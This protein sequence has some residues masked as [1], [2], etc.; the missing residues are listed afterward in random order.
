MLNFVYYLSL[1]LTQLKN[2]TLLLHLS[3]WI[4]VFLFIGLLFYTQNN[5][6]PKPIMVKVCFG[7]VLFYINYSILIPRFLFKR[8]FALYILLAA[9]L[10]AVVTV[11]YTHIKFSVLMFEGDSKSSK[12]FFTAYLF[13]IPLLFSILLK[14]FN[15]WN[16]DEKRKLKISSKK[17]TSELQSLKNQINPHFLFNSLNSIYSLTLQ[18]SETAPDAVMMLS[19]LM[20]YMLYETNEDNVPLRKEIEYIENYI[21]LQKLQIANSENIKLNVH[22]KVSNQKISP[23][24]LISFIENAFKYGTDFSGNT[25]IDIDIYV[26]GNELQFKCEN[27]I[28]NR[29]EA[30]NKE[31]GGIGIKNTKERLNLSYPN[32]HWLAIKENENTYQVKLNLK[33]E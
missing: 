20:R 26:K 3:A 19:D 4:I 15:Q 8:K 9:V 12:Y 6:I 2:K 10:V 5:S 27:I 1:M 33:L 7:L 24:L 18:N 16:K 17:V 31:Y 22:G 21:D 30:S 13:T 14:F 11:V 25:K 28:G 32:G 29:T 23:L